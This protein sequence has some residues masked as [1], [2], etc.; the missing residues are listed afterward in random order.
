MRV[1]ETKDKI[2]SGSVLPQLSSSPRCVAGL[3]AAALLLGLFAGRVPADPPETPLPQEMRAKLDELVRQLG[4]EQFQQRERAQQELQRIGLPAFDV[5]NDAKNHP[6]IEIALRV[7]YLLESMKVR[8]ASDDDSKE[9]RRVLKNYGEQHESIRQSMIDRLASLD[10]DP[11]DALCRLARFET[12]ERLSKRAALTLMDRSVQDAVKAETAGRIR[13]ALGYSR[14]AATEWLRVYAQTLEAPEQTLAQWNE[15]VR[16]ERSELAEFPERSTDEIVRKLIHW[17]VKV[18]QRVS[19]RPQALAV[20]RQT[21]DLLGNSRADVLSTVDWFLS[22]QAWELVLELA[23]RYPD[24]FQ[25][26]LILQYRVAEAERGKGLQ[27]QAEATAAKA[28]EA[29]P[30]DLEEHIEAAASLQERGLI[31]WAEAELKRV[32]KDSEPA[33]THQLRA[34]FML[35]EM[36]HDFQRE[37][38]AAETLQVVSDLLEKDAALAKR[39][40]APPLSRSLGGIRSRMHFFYALH[41]AA[42]GDREKQIQHLRDG[43]AADATDADLLIGMYRVTE[44]TEEWKRLT[45]ER[46]D[47]AANEFMQQIVR[48]R[49][50]LQQS[51]DGASKHSIERALASANNQYAWLVSNTVGDY[52]E[53]LRCSKESVELLPDYAGYLDTLGRCYYAVGDYANA[54][55]FQQRAVDLEPHSGQIRRQLEMFQRA[56]REKTSEKDTREETENRTREESDQNAPADSEKTSEKTSENAGEAAQRG[57]PPQGVPTAPKDGE[58]ATASPN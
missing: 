7:K 48:L 43:L 36:L 22:N 10:V 19:Q 25:E 5:L 35:S 57:A 46:I 38:E 14:R 18:L 30:E 6:D 20:M 41:F 9:V 34:R 24:L 15:L 23:Q 29:R 44:P 21:I 27:E 45:R 54:V 26:Q 32:L 42:Q 55:K 2:M 33:S 58:P 53:A 47:A 8:W 37:L 28:R 56:L 40:S 4:S 52:D 3:L 12:S 16:K 51:Q 49:Q 13:R 11:T 17:Q 31:T 39:L 50:Y 1:S